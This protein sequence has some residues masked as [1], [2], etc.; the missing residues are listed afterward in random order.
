M[1]SFEKE[2]LWNEGRQ[3][4]LDAPQ[5]F[6]DVDVEADG[7]AG[8]GSLLALGAVALG[9]ETF[10]SELKPLYETFLPGNRAFCE[11]HNLERERLI[12]E[13]P[14]AAQVMQEFHEWVT[15]LQQKYDK[16]TV[17][18]GLNAG[19][20][21]A[22]VD[23]YFALHGLDNPFG[24]AGDDLKSLVM[25]LGGKWDWHDTKKSRIPEIIKP[26]GEFTHHALEDALYQ[27]KIH[28]GAAALLANIQRPPAAVL[29]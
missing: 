27:Q 23:L 5:Q 17:F 16:E 1:T 21:W 29:L 11:A 20:D 28:F 2:K 12:E 22:L 14:E 24:I 25:P 15:G 26:E 4:L 18:V 13:A 8:Y 6:I 3:I 10:Y 7:I 19:F 9:G